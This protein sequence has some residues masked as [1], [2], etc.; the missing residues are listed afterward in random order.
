MK[1][2]ALLLRVFFGALFRAFFPAVFAEVKESARDT[3]GDA[4]PQPELRSRLQS[5]VRARW[6]RRAMAG[7]SL[8][9]ALTCLAGCG[10]KTIFV[11]DGESVRLRKPIH[12]AAVWVMDEDGKPVASKVT[13]PAGWYCVHDAEAGADL[14]APGSEDATH[15]QTNI[16]VFSP[17]PF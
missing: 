2:F 14:P 11:A 1:E 6:G 7:G 16:P 8:A 15:I 3:C 5:R 17:S 9:L 10:T 12:R 13:L 4:Q